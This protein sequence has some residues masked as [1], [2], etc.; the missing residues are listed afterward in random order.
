MYDVPRK[1]VVILLCFHADGKDN[2]DRYP[3]MVD[4]GHEHASTRQTQES[5][6]LAGPLNAPHRVHQ[7]EH[8]SA[9]THNFVQKR[10]EPAR[11][12]RNMVHTQVRDKPSLAHSC[13]RLGISPV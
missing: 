4:P 8:I 7:R 13:V 2:L 9:G 11:R 10:V 3:E 12:P 1:L 5:Q 6:S